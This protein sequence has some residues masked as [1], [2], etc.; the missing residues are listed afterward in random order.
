MRHASVY[1][2][3]CICIGRNTNNQERK[4]GK[5][6]IVC[7]Y[8]PTINAV[9]VDF[10]SAH[11]GSLI[12]RVVKSLLVAHIINIQRVMALTSTRFRVTRVSPNNCRARFQFGGL[13]LPCLPGWSRL[14]QC[15]TFHQPGCRLNPLSVPEYAGM[16]SLE[17]GLCIH[18]KKIWI[19]Y[20][21]GS[22]NITVQVCTFKDYMFFHWQ[23]SVLGIPHA[24]R[25][26]HKFVKFYCRVKR[27]I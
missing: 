4:E 25:W 5:N 17:G 23:L 2:C 26:V 14:T 10:H 21:L 12:A 20:L 3:I 22:M 18:R 11:P 8:F 1:I 13:S 16:T 24:L 15:P 19:E 27:F 6:F 9:G 7:F